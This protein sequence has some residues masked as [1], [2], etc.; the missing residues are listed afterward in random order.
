[1]NDKLAPS[2]KREPL[3]FPYDNKQITRCLWWKRCQKR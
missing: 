1:M 3:S 2:C